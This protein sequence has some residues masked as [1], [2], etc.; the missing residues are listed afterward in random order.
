MDINEKRK[1][2]AIKKIVS[3]EFLKNLLK[4]LPPSPKPWRNDNDKNSVVDLS[5]I[6][7]NAPWNLE[8]AY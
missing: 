4:D 8:N 2:Y 3:N 1:K 7:K 5:K 6:K